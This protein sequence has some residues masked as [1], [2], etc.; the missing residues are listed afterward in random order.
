MVLDESV[1]LLVR[2]VV[3]VDVDDV[4]DVVV[5]DDDDDDDDAVL[6]SSRTYSRG[7]G[8]CTYVGAMMYLY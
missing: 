1:S 2:L 3:V 6:G 7:D 4:D 8:Y 5:D